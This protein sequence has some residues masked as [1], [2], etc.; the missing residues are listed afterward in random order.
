MVGILNTFRVIIYERTREIG[1]MRALGM[2]RGTVRGLFIL[3]ALFM[4]VGGVA[5]G[6]A[7]FALIAG[8]LSAIRFPLDIPF[9][10][11]LARGRLLFKVEP[12]RLAAY[13][14]GVAAITVLAALVP[15]VRAAR[16][17]P[18]RSLRTTY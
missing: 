12:V 14:A 15:A 6:L 16:M 9:A 3:E 17:E 2:Q 11:F 7:L 8:V 10:A 1:T 5:V 4:S 18:A 13:L